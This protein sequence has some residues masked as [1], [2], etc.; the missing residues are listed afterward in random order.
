MVAPVQRVE[1]RSAPSPVVPPFRGNLLGEARWQLELAGLLLSGIHRGE[2]VR[3]GDGD[4][5]LAV[6]GFLAGDTSLAVLRAWLRR[7]GYR[8]YRSGIAWNVDCSEAAVRRLDRRLADVAA[9]AGR[10]VT[11]IGHSRGGLLAHAV[12]V[13][14]P[15]RVRR[16]ITLGSPLSSPFDASV[17]TLAAVG[18]ARLGQNL[19][20]PAR[21]Q[22]LTVGCPCAF[23][24]D[25][26]APNPVPVTSIRTVEDGIVRP[27]SCVVDG[28]ENVAVRGS[29]VGLCVNSD[30]YREIARLL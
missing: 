28:A 26:R 7:C 8:A 21:P 29:H 27:E 20:R 6:P 25:L 4:P 9:R 10:P 11:V 24:A 2:G 14:R 12:A 18:G 1:L 15:N 17:L 30:V 16:V 13:R 3:P 19:L 23:G 22:C 5:V